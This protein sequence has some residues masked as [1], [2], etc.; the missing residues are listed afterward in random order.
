MS[1]FLQVCNACLQWKKCMKGLCDDRAAKE[2][3]ILESEENLD[4][5]DG[6]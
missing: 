1:Y 6:A 5:E 2:K 3:E 4:K